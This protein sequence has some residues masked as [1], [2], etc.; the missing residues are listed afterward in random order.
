[1]P[2]TRREYHISVPSTDKAIILHAPSVKAFTVSMKKREILDDASDVAV[3]DDTPPSAH[4]G[5]TYV[6]PSSR[7]SSQASHTGEPPSAHPGVTY[8]SPSS[9]R[10]SQAS[11]TGEHTIRLD[12]VSVPTLRLKL[13]LLDPSAGQSEDTATNR[14]PSVNLILQSSISKRDEEDMERNQR[15]EIQD[16]FSDLVRDRLRK[17]ERL[18]WTEDSLETNVRTLLEKLKEKLQKHADSLMR[19]RV[20]ATIKL[21]VESAEECFKRWSEEKGTLKVDSEEESRESDEHSSVID[22]N[23]ITTSRDVG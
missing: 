11:H 8:V 16:S 9:R 3:V 7:R 6:S 22:L 13:T 17:A 4:P 18:G 12:N 1:M 23:D 19:M 5:V 10:S 15:K 20:P 2:R 21:E 14:L